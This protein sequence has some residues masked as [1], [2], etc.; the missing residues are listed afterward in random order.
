[1]CVFIFK[2]GHV[3]PTPDVTRTSD[4]MSFKELRLRGLEKEFVC[5]AMM[6]YKVVSV[7][8]YHYDFD[9][10]YSFFIIWYYCEL[11]QASIQGALWLAWGDRGGCFL[12]HTLKDASAILY[13]NLRDG[14]T[15]FTLCQASPW[16][17]P[18][19]KAQIEKGTMCA[20]ADEHTLFCSR[21]MTFIPCTPRLS[22]HE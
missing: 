17:C 11:S 7:F 20:H 18:T 3:K 16:D 22:A 9:E 10:S 19:W 4:Q 13:E 5:K 8:I 2:A 12:L 1:M 6:T 15:L 14:L 21:W